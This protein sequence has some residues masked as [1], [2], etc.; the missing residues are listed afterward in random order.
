M[1]YTDVMVLIDGAVEYQE[2]FERDEEEVLERFLEDVKAEA[3]D[4][5]VVAE[6][7]V[8]YH[9]HPLDGDEC[10]CVQ[11]LQNHYPAVVFGGAR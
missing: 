9:D 4:A 1:G 10:G 7:F 2:V 11:Y 5:G 6:C 8:L 3:E